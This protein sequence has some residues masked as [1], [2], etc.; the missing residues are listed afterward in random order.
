MDP[1]MNIQRYIFHY[2]T[3]SQ[4]LFFLCGKKIALIFQGRKEANPTHLE[5]S[6]FKGLLVM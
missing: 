2:T 3:K 6:D 1:G 4:D 5:A